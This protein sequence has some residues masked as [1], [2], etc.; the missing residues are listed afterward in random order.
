MMSR[1]IAAL[2]AVAGLLSLQW[3]GTRRDQ[4]AGRVEQQRDDAE[5]R[6]DDIH[7]VKIIHDH[8]DRDNDYADG[9]RER[10]TRD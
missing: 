7:Q 2:A 5:G 1:I 8:L 10:F 6:L 3:M 9:V 4:E